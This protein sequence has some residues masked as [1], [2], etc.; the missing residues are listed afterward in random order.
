MGLFD[1]GNS[2]TKR[3]LSD[4][5]NNGDEPKKQLENG[6]QT[7]E[8]STCWDDVFLVGL[9]D[10]ESNNPMIKFM[11]LLEIKD[12]FASTEITKNSQIKGEQHLNKVTESIDFIEKQFDSFKK[13][14]EEKD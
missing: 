6:S 3:Q 8:I 14:L 4:Q 5:S 7:E 2:S 12:L 10:S 1:K 11:K 13:Q 9:E